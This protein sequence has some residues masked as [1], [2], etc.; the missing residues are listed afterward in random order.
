[1]TVARNVVAATNERAQ[2]QTLQ[3]FMCSLVSAGLQAA[4][5][6]LSASARR[7]SPANRAFSLGLSDNL[8]LFIDA[9]AMGLESLRGLRKS[10]A[11][12]GKNCA[13]NSFSRGLKN[14]ACLA[15][16]VWLLFAS[17]PISPA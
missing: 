4:G 13:G 10:R 17:S 3:C 16:G 6:D 15:A 9:A 7:D 8:Q 12:E 14:R 2:N 11:S 5:S 1:M